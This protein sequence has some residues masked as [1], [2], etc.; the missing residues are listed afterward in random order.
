MEVQTLEGLVRQVDLVLS[1][2][3]IETEVKKELQKVAR[4]VKVEGFRP[5]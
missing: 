5:D 2:D 4:K 3:E 1:V